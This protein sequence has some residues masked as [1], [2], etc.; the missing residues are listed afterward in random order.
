MRN[1]ETG[2]LEQ[3]SA[4]VYYDD[5]LKGMG[6]SGAHFLSLPPEQRED[7]LR[8]NKEVGAR[9]AYEITADVLDIAGEDETMKAVGTILSEIAD[10][11]LIPTVIA[12]GGGTVPLLLSGGLYGL[13][14]E[15]SRQPH[16][17]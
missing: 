6:M 1:P 2:R 8:K 10:P 16:Q 12:S 4:E 17:D 14:S 7:I 13:A 15:G 3:V 5:A 9:E 11:L